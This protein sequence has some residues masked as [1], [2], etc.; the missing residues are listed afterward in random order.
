MRSWRERRSPRRFMPPATPE[1]IEHTFDPLVV[2]RRRYQTAA[3]SARGS[4][5]PRD[6][7]RG[8]R[9]RGARHKGRGP[10][11]A[12]PKA[13]EVPGPSLSDRGRNPLLLWRM[14]HHPQWGVRLAATPW[15]R[16]AHSGTTPRAA[17]WAREVADSPPAS[18]ATLPRTAPERRASPV[19]AGVAAVAARIGTPRTSP[20]GSGGA[21]GRR[22]G[23]PPASRVTGGH[24]SQCRQ[25]LPAPGRPRE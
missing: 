15:R 3:T 5:S 13:S 14:P 4:G 24:H 12:G 10:G 9:P 23:C 7:V 19:Q 2:D 25:V 16:G 6:A 17:G 20:A 22:Q 21:S 8:I 18:T 1:D 11:A